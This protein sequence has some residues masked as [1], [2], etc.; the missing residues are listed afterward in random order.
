VE[1]EGELTILTEKT[2]MTLMTGTTNYFTKILDTVVVQVTEVVKVIQ[3]TETARVSVA[4][5]IK[6]IPVTEIVKVSEVFQVIEVGR[7]M[8]LTIKTTKMTLKLTVN[9]K[10][11]EEADAIL[12]WTATETLTTFTGEVRELVEEDILTEVLR[13]EISLQEI[14]NAEV[15]I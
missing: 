10:A 9:V 15:L 6:T 12:A 8:I 4:V 2:T 7:M 5:K 11:T 1:G 3:V 14:L 13:I